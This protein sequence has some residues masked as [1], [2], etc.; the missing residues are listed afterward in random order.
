MDCA[1]RSGFVFPSLEVLRIGWREFRAPTVHLKGL[2]PRFY[3]KRG[4]FSGSGSTRETKTNS[5][6]VP[7][8]GRESSCGKPVGQNGLLTGSVRSSCVGGLCRGAGRRPSKVSLTKTIGK[9]V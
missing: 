8:F 3:A 6:S 5:E 9:S 1:M 7:N 2:W 4:F